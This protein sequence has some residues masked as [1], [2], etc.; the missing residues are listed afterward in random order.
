MGAE[1]YLC[2]TT[3]YVHALILPI[4]RVIGSC[5]MTCIIQF[6]SLL[7]VYSM[8]FFYKFCFVLVVLLIL[9][10]LFC[11]WVCS[12]IQKP[13]KIEKFS[14]SLIACVVFIT[15]EFG[16]VHSYLR[17]SAFTSLTCYVCTYIFVGEILKTLCDF[18]K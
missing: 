6:V 11:F 10:Y 12:K 9:L 1:G 17:H 4:F 8:Y 18:W 7:P 3:S 13:I 16:L 2:M 5:I 14:K 15:C